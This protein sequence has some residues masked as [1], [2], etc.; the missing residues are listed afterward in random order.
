MQ[1]HLNGPPV[2]PLSLAL[3]LLGLAVS[4]G[5]TL[6]AMW[7][8]RRALQ[9]L[10]E[11]Q[12]QEEASGGMEMVRGDS[13]G[14]SVGPRGL[15]PLG[16]P[17]WGEDEELGGREGSSRRIMAVIKETVSTPLWKRVGDNEGE[18][19]GQ[20]K[21]LLAEINQ[22]E[23][24]HR[25]LNA[26]SS[27]SI[28]MKTHAVDGGRELQEAIRLREPVGKRDD[29]MSFE[30]IAASTSQDSEAHFSEVDLHDAPNERLS[31]HDQDE[32]KRSWTIH[33]L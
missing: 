32:S 20:S 17:L 22:N 24:S 1:Q 16:G 13:L 26:G 15:S 18:L 30:E 23:G 33:Q 19:E 10:E 28:L 3:E 4:S 5:V 27:T 9:E 31:T 14:H 11:Q 7:Y 29:D 25:L 8:G 21:R 12:R 2:S 6:T